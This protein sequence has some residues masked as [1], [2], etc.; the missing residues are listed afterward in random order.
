MNFY[1]PEPFAILIPVYVGCLIFLWFN[2][3]DKIWKYLSL[4]VVYIAY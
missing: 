2:L 4:L 1:S 3:P